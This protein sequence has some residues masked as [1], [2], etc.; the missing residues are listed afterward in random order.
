MDWRAII[1]AMIS[2]IVPY[3]YNAIIGWNAGFP[4]D[5]ANFNEL[6][7]WVFGLLLN[8]IGLGVAGWF[9]KDAVISYKLKKSN[10]HA[11]SIGKNIV[12][13]DG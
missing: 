9:V 1:L 5:Q 6:V 13:K 8:G 11:I 4:L 2:I 7:Q 12:R 10:G 3:L